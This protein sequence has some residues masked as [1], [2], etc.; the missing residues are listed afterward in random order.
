MLGSK[1]QCLHVRLE[2]Y[3]SK[4]MGYNCVRKEIELLTEKS[5][6]IS[7]ISVNVNYLNFISSALVLQNIFSP[8]AHREMPD[9]RVSKKKQNNN[10]NVGSDC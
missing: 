5:T 10:K 4:Q 2:T 6:M 3:C 1:H 8:G 7:E 9:E